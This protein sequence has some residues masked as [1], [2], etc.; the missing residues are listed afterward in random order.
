MEL[1]FDAPKGA[2][3]GKRVGGGGANMLE[4]AISVSGPGAALA[5][6]SVG[7]GVMT[8]FS[9]LLFVERDWQPAWL[10]YTAFTFAFVAAGMAFGHLPD[11]R[12]G[13]ARIAALFA[14]IE[15]I[16]FAIL[17]AAPVNWLGVVGAAAVGFGYDLGVTGV[18]EMRFGA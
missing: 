12:I 7:F 3:N 14:I 5:L 1:V 2:D 18:P 16:G 4:V 13:G 15:A 8:A 6:A 11:H 9:V 17:W 10:S